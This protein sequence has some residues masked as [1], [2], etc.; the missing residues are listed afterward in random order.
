VTYSK[1]GGVIYCGMKPTASKRHPHKATSR[2]GFFINGS[3]ILTG[4][5]TGKAFSVGAGVVFKF[6]LLR[7]MSEKPGYKPPYDPQE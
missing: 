1:I 5:N 6:D 3:Y 4:V 2:C 7:V